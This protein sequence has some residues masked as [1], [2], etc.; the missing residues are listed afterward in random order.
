MKKKDK[1][2]ITLVVVIF[3]MIC[4]ALVLHIK[5]NSN[6]S[7]NGASSGV[8]GS[9][10]GLNAFDSA[11]ITGALAVARQTPNSS[12]KSN[13]DAFISS[14][15]AARNG[16]SSKYDLGVIKNQLI[17]YQVDPTLGSNAAMCFVVAPPAIVKVK[18]F[19][20]QWALYLQPADG[21]NGSVLIVQ[22][23]I[24][25]CAQAIALAKATPNTNRAFVTANSKSLIKTAVLSLPSTALTK[26]GLYILD[27]ARG[28]L[29]QN[30]K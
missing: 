13:L 5:T 10:A 12:N 7:V 14:L 25:T 24:S 23:G 6:T 29:T 3:V 16:D 15:A 17:D 26:T 27:E 30:A 1:I 11:A 28:L 4:L 9:V 2:A 22:K 20:A 21:S 18:P 19:Q 8:K